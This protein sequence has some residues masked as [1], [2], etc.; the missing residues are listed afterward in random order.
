MRFRLVVDGDPHEVEARRR[1][2]RIV[3]RVDGVEYEAQAA[4]GN[5][6]V[7]VRIRGTRYRVRIRGLDVS[8]EGEGH[9][10]LVRDLAAEALPPVSR[11]RRARGQVYEI[12]PPM[13]GR[14]VRLRVHAGARVRAGEPIAVLEAMKMQNEIPAPADALVREVHVREGESIGAD[15]LIAVLES[16]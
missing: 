6:E 10:V 13:P 1:G 9:E 12:R 4:G 3:V 7:A 2:R 5:G 8:V 16:L 11:G 15:R 14:V